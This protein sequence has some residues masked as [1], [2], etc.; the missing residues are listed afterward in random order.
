M[1]WVAAAAMALVL[2]ASCGGGVDREKVTMGE[3][4]IAVC[5]SVD[6]L[7]TA[8]SFMS[9]IASG[10]TQRYAE[11][12]QSAADEAD[13]IRAEVDALDPPREAK[14]YHRALLNVLN[15]ISDSYSDASSDLAGVSDR[16]VVFAVLIDSAAKIAAAIET[17]DR[18]LSGSE[19]TE[20]EIALG[21][22]GCNP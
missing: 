1:R 12:A 14:A 11:S 13:A 19:N 2:L 9:A 15:T 8:N 20:A 4:A 10:A 6:R 21:L 18:N 22:A 5:R 16:E 7:E 3:W 17:L